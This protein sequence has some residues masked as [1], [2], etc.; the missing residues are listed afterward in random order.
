MSEPTK[1]EINKAKFL[2]WNTPHTDESMKDAISK[3][4]ADYRMEL[5][6]HIEEVHSNHAYAEAIENYGSTKRRW[7]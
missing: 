7:V 4:L 1:V 6:K 2:I 3:S 5:A